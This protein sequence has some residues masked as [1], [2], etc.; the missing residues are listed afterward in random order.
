MKTKLKT[1]APTARKISRQAQVIS[2]L[3]EQLLSMAAALEVA[4]KESAR[5]KTELYTL[6]SGPPVIHIPEAP[7]ADTY[8]AAA[9]Q[10]NQKLWAFRRWAADKLPG[11]ALP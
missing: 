8:Y 1:G 10:M 6:R 4:Q 7:D 9:V 11:E 3:S 2:G 5:L